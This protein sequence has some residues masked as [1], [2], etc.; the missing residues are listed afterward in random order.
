MRSTIWLWVCLCLVPAAAAGPASPTPEVLQQLDALHTQTQAS[1][2]AGDLQACVAQANQALVLA[3]EHLAGDA[4][5]LATSLN[6]LG[7]CLEAAGDYPGAEALYQEGLDI[8]VA[9]ERV[10]IVPVI[11]SCNNMG[12]VREA[13][14]DTPDALEWYWTAWNFLT[15]HQVSDP[16]AYIVANNLASASTA[17][18]DHETAETLYL[19]VLQSYE[20]LHGTDHLLTAQAQNNLAFLYG[21]LGRSSDAKALYELALAT[22]ED[23]AP[24]HP[25]VANV[26]GNLAFV[27]QSEGDVAGAERHLQRALEIRL[28][29][30]G[31]DHPDVA[32]SRINLAAV[33]SSAGDFARTIPELDAALASLE[34]SL[35]PD[36]PL[37]A[38]AL[39]SR[40]SAALESGDL[41]G[42][43]RFLERALA[44]LEAAHGPEHPELAYPL[45]SLC[46]LEE[47]LG[48]Y[49]QALAAAERAVAL[50]EAGHGPEHPELGQFLTA[51]GAVQAAL[52]DH[53]AARASYHRAVRVAEVAWGP[54]S[55][56]AGHAW[57]ALGALLLEEGDLVEALVVLARARS[58]LE[59]ALGSDHAETTAVLNN[60]AYGL[61][62][63]GHYV[64]ARSLY[65]QALAI[66]ER[67]YG[68]DHP[69]PAT[70]LHNLGILVHEQGDAVEARRYYERALRL[71]E[72]AYGPVHPSVATTLDK[73]AD[74]SGWQGELDRAQD[75]ASRSLAIR[76]EVLG[77]DHPDVGHSQV[78]LAMLAHRA[79][80]LFGAA[81][82]YQAAQATWAAAGLGRTDQATRVRVLQG[83][84]A[85]D[86]G[87]VA[88][89][90]GLLEQALDEATARS[91]PGEPTRAWIERRLALALAADGQLD[92]AR[93]LAGRSLRAGEATLGPV[94]SRASERARL[95]MVRS[96]RDSLDVVLS[97]MDRPGD[98]GLAYRGVLRWK[99]V[100]TR[101]LVAQQGQLRASDDPELAALLAE[102]AQVRESLARLTW[103][104]QGGELDELTRRKEDLQRD[105]ATR[106]AVVGQD[107]RVVEADA[108]SLCA[109]L[110][111]G[112]ALVDLLRYDHTTAGPGTLDTS[113]RY[114][115]FVL[116]S[117]ACDQVQRV[118]LGSA[119][120]LETRVERHRELLAAQSLT[121]R[122]DKAGTALR[123][124]VWD[125]LASALGDA[126]PVLIVPDG[127]LAT[128]AFGALPTA[129]RYLLEDRQIGYLEAAQDLLPAP[130]APGPRGEG[131]LVV[132]GVAY[133][134][135]APTAVEVPQLAQTRAAACLADLAP[136]PATVT[137]VRAVQ[138]ALGDPVQLLTGL[139]ASEAQVAAAVQGKRVV[140]LATHGF[141]A[142]EGCRSA[143]ISN[144]GDEAVLGMNPMLLSGL[145]LAGANAGGAGG[146]DG[147]WTAEEIA[148]LSLAGTELVVLSACDTALGTVEAGE[149]VLGLRRAFTLT[150]A[151]TTVM[152]LWPVDDVATAQLMAGLYDA[153]DGQPAAAALRQAQL[154]LLA[155]NRAA[156]EAR[157]ET[158]AA[159]IAS[160]GRW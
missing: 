53:P 12:S 30:L 152:S 149:G 145:A 99:G 153:L 75:L 38:T 68:P 57:N 47:E 97:L 79:G 27:L 104:G 103:A 43:R 52:G 132:G 113:P 54:A 109:A 35:G 65:E 138:Q 160:G 6:N 83:G 139:D 112:G 82:G 77:D 95:A 157:P 122:I 148:G 66:E 63:Q 1:H 131:A 158:W 126:D 73:L 129:D 118:D 69:E 22:W 19:W 141:F 124:R 28:E 62:E 71:K 137:E 45:Y 49:E 31:P 13:Q 81:A 46:Q 110:P 4:P 9:S 72:R 140:H 128:V 96:H 40:G 84:V 150:G 159:F 156:G 146:G 59:G 115:A 155:A 20:L 60:L 116:H 102:L 98:A 136:L 100:A 21:E 76:Q 134:D 61:S 105:L 50:F 51:R 88:G 23:Q 114:A 125:P 86:Q 26:H 39:S 17:A 133:D 10:G 89:A 41:V 92:R 91:A 151:G 24:D 120:A 106:S 11:V 108:A 142:G 93:D 130:E 70:L 37:V 117:Q 127:A 14:G 34:R 107:L 147:V 101:S 25:A 80:D 2:T 48:R 32:V 154:D 44:V 58:I 7:G 5:R 18:G 143:L 36:H 33:L 16:V 55:P 42:A 29:T 56:A 123:E 94:L 111:P 74:L 67:V 85:F 64:E 15:E 90:V 87:D 135:K 8:R 121:T 3:R 119:E 144:G 78:Q